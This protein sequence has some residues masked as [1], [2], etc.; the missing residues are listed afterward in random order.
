MN[1]PTAPQP[2][3]P[4]T[5]MQP[6]LDSFPSPL[7]A[8]RWAFPSCAVD[9]AEWFRT[10]S[11]PSRVVRLLRRHMGDLASPISSKTAHNMA[12]HAVKEPPQRQQPFTAAVGSARAL[13][14]QGYINIDLGNGNGPQ[15]ATA[16]DGTRVAV[17][18]GVP[19]PTPAQQQQ[20]QQRRAQLVAQAKAN[21]ILNAQ[22]DDEGRF[23][24]GVHA[25][26]GSMVQNVNGSPQSDGKP[27]ADR[28]KQ[29]Q[30]Q[31]NRPAVAPASL[32][33]DEQ[34]W[35][36]TF[37]SHDP[38]GSQPPS[39]PST[40]MPADLA[41]TAMSQEQATAAHPWTPPTVP[42]AGNPVPIT[43]P[44][45]V[46]TYGNGSATT[47]A[48]AAYAQQH[49]TGGYGMIP[50]APGQ[51]A[52]THVSDG[53]LY[54][55]GQA[56]PA[57]GT[58]TFLPDG[59]GIVGQAPAA[60]AAPAP[61]PVAASA[62]PGQGIGA[63]TAGSSAFKRPANPAPAASP[64]APPVSATPAP[65]ASSDYVAQTQA[66]VKAY[67][68]LGVAGSPE[69]TR[70]DE[71]FYTG[72]ADKNHVLDLA[73]SMF[74]PNSQQSG[75][76]APSS[77]I[78]GWSNP[79]KDWLDSL[80]SRGQA[81]PPLA[82]AN[83]T[84]VPGS[85]PATPVAPVAPAS[86]TPAS[87][88]AAYPERP[89]PPAPADPTATVAGLFNDLQHGGTGA[90]PAP[91]AYSAPKVYD[92]N[93]P[94]SQPDATTDAQ[95][96]YI[97]NLYPTAPSIPP[98]PVGIAPT[99]MAAMGTPTLPTPNFT[100]PAGPSPAG[101][102]TPGDISTPQFALNTGAASTP[103]PEPLGS[104]GP[105]SSSTP[106]QPAATAANPP[107]GAPASATS[108]ALSPQVQRLTNAG[109]VSTSPRLPS[110]TST[111]PI[112]VPAATPKVSVNGT[113]S[114]LGAG[115]TASQTPA[116]TSS[117]SSAGGPQVTTN[118]APARKPVDTAPADL[119]DPDEG[120]TAKTFDD[121]TSAATAPTSAG[122]DNGSNIPTLPTASSALGGALPQSTASQ[123]L[124][125]A[126][127]AAAALGHSD[128][129]VTPGWDS[130][131]PASSK[132]PTI[133]DASAS[134][135]VNAA[136]PMND[137]EWKP[138]TTPG[139]GVDLDKPINLSL[140]AAAPSQPI[141]TNPL[142]GPNDPTQ[143]K[144]GAGAAA[145]APDDELKKQKAQPANT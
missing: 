129:G 8:A 105:S 51:S 108:P 23:I 86:S 16:P 3:Y 50:V 29:A 26:D 40:P 95:M 44:T 31:S 18:N 79:G 110:A 9:H 126:P 2:K 38:Q 15:A 85:A 24:S 141:P 117:S 120:T 52:Q 12:N 61:S 76:A 45:A 11:L 60:P 134:T 43:G 35:Q 109:L 112:I 75:T 5:W 88:P 118:G 90:P 21:G 96:A 145:A 91:P 140:T 116:P 63:S 81:T 137:D 36:D 74:G 87:A 4:R 20:I 6:F 17:K 10:F 78:G 13:E 25:T 139:S 62:A 41:L 42:G 104:T 39:I 77:V 97:R 14:Q 98:T 70:F 49:P 64:A 56:I 102:L 142:G 127:S 128:G 66:A 111:N 144:A 135:A 133:P 132:P 123:T 100:P 136:T 34:N 73:N 58:L 46:S 27:N 103:K 72:G 1:E 143:P 65:A 28:L 68:A 130:A 115:S 7:A 67:P 32:S 119:P 33:P 92:R 80:A 83:P 124:A 106:S 89:A 55:K 19:Q 30:A 113:P 101:T 107:A 53:N 48:D 22:F 93:D 47:A 84:P 57:G 82:A 114:D 71:A 138:P 99:E 94:S 121:G 131:V 125:N 122:R 69:N 37:H 54:W 59:R